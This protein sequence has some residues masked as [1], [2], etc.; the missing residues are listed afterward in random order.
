MGARGGTEEQ[1]EGQPWS[2]VLPTRPLGSS[3][4]PQELPEKVDNLR[5]REQK[6][7]IPRWPKTQ[8]GK[9]GGDRKGRQELATPEGQQGRQFLPV[10]RSQLAAVG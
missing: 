3:L 6:V 10:G 2:W 9:I 5:K 7:V 8:G 1:D 4:G